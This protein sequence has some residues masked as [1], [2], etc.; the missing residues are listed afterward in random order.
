M[1][2]RCAGGRVVKAQATLTQTPTQPIRVSG[3]GSQTKATIPGTI[4]AQTEK[5]RPLHADPPVPAQ[6]GRSPLEGIAD[7][8]DILPTTEACVELTHRLLTMAPTLPAGES[9]PKAI[10]KTVILFIAEYD[11]TAEGDTCMESREAGLLER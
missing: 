10:L 8:L 6:P 1:E 11:S 2:P 9:R 7:L 5:L 4:V 3:P